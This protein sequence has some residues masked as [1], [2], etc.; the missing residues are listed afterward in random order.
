MSIEWTTD[1]KPSREEAERL[2]NGGALA[3]IQDAFRD[4]VLVG[5]EK[6]VIGDGN[7][8]EIRIVLRHKSALPKDPTP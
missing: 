6:R 3:D 7:D 5:M 8:L 1:P 2:V 4:G